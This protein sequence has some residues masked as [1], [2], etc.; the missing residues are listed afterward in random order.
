MEEKARGEVEEGTS[1]HSSSVA[2]LNF[3]FCSHVTDF[4]VRAWG[5]YVVVECDYLDPNWFNL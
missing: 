1:G 5:G 4:T 2:G 3:R